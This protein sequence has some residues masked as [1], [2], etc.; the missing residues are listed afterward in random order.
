MRILMDESLLVQYP[1]IERDHFWWVSRRELVRGLIRGEGLG[2]DSTVL[3]VGC[4]SG[5]LSRELSRLGTNVTGVDVAGHLEWDSENRDVVFHEGDFLEMSSDLGTFDCLLAL[6]VMEHVETEKAFVDALGR[7]VRPGGLVVVTVPAYQWMWSRHDEIN[8]H[9]RRYTKKRL[10]AALEGG[11]LHVTRCGYIFFGL[12]VPKIVSKG[13]ERLRDDDGVGV[14]SAPL[15]RGALTYF[16]WEHRLAN[17]F[18]NFLPA[19]TSVI[20]VCRRRP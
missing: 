1:E 8:H 18:R 14:P 16:R 20:A 17:R 19:G 3:D 9:F 6:D 10:V 12:I 5:V 4:G 2:D 15:N 11:D 13:A 7:N